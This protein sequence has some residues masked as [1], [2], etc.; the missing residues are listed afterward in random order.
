VTYSG[1]TVDGA[2]IAFQWLAGQNFAGRQP[3]QLWANTL[4][5]NATGVLVQSNGVANLYRNDITGSGDGAGVHVVTGSLLPSGPVPTA[6]QEN[7]IRNGSG[8][9]ILIEAAA[10]PIGE[11][12]DN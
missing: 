8:D 12:F 2:N 5:N 11:I 7:F 4:T 10:G 6:V 3:V 1:N 9:G